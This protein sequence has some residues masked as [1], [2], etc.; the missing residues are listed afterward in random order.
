MLTPSRTL[1]QSCATVALIA[2]LSISCRGTS[3]T[4]AVRDAGSATAVSRDGSVTIGGHEAGK[5]RHALI[6]AGV[7][8]Q[9]GDMGLQGLAAN[10]V[11]CHNDH[12]T[13]S[14]EECVVKTASEDL[15]VVGAPAQVLFSTLKAHKPS[16]SH[17]VTANSVSCNWLVSGGDGSTHCTFN[18]AD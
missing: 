11:T 5:F 3:D 8:T 14:P 10:S 7:K 18:F 16:Q 6:D 13:A 15:P 12:T 9:L 2:T 17:T 4:S 1:S